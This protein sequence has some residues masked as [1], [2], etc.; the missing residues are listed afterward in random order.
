MQEMLAWT[1]AVPRWRS[2]AAVCVLL[3]LAETG[4]GLAMPWLAAELAAG[5]LTGDTHPVRAVLLPL[6]GVLSLQA[7]LHYLSQRQSASLAHR[8]LAALRQRVYDHL[9]SLPL[10]VWQQ[11]ARGDMLSVLANDVERLADYLNA[12]VLGLV[13]AVLA[14]CG[15]WLLM[16]RIDS[17]L[18]LLALALLPLAY[19]VLKLVGRGLRPVAAQMQEAQA[20]QLAMADEN[21]ELLPLIKAHARETHE[22][23]RF[24]DLT[25]QT[26]SLG[27]KQVAL[28]AALSP[29]VRWLAAMAMVL[30]LLA[31]GDSTAK[32]PAQMI[33]FMLYVAMLTRPLGELADFYGQTRQALGAYERVR[34]LMSLPIEPAGLDNALTLP[35]PPLA[36]QGKD[37][38]FESIDFAYPGRLPVFAGF[39]LAIAS[40]ECVA[41]TG[42]NGCGKST[43]ALLLLRMM[44]LGAGRILLDGRDMTQM[45]LPHVRKSIGLVAQQVQLAHASIGENIAWGLPTATDAQIRQAARQ[46]RAHDFIEALPQGY[47]TI[48][49]DQGLRLSGGQRQKI[50][51]ARALLPDPSILILDEATAMW[52]EA[53]EADLIEQCQ[54]VFAGRTVIII[55]HRPALLAL[56][57]RI[58]QL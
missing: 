46:A 6:V 40:G 55:T 33:A 56:A 5:V 36:K 57:H 43:L 13:P 54:S 26:L 3:M 2:L 48:V 21:F 4:F 11:R 7:V 45:P 14:V 37:I 1:Q 51:L 27:L 22:S 29:V 42:P 9:Q 30:L 20:R 39:N 49:G 15:A 23:H 24:A 47:D 35:E 16:L 25:T 38:R 50:A 10:A 17:R 34:A 18:A 44:P 12:T 41:L 32:T 53:S 19:G 52:D 58:I 31:L 8:A 28:Q